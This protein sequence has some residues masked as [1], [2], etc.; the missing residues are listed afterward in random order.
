LSISQRQRNGNKTPHLLLMQL[1]FP[2][3]AN[4]HASLWFAQG[5]HKS[6]QRLQ[7]NKTST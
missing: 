3:W 5:C 7:D 6:S 4:K 1:M 2:V